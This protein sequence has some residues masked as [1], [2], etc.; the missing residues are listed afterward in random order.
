MVR[1]TPVH[2]H[3][4]TALAALAV[5]AC[6]TL[7][8]HWWTKPGGTVA[9]AGGVESSSSAEGPHRR[10]RT[11]LVLLYFG[12]STCHWCTSVE[13]LEAVRA[14]LAA[15]HGRAAQAGY[16]VTAVGV[17]LDDD[18]DEGLRY[19]ADV[20]KWDQIVS[21]GS[22]NNLVARHVLPVQGT[23][24]LAVFMRTSSRIEVPGGR[25]AETTRKNELIVR[26]VGLFEIQRW[27]ELGAPI[28]VGDLVPDQGQ[29]RQKEIPEEL[30]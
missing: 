20:A 25:I 30:F 28:P 4:M 8:A 5:F 15:V 9:T 23:P 2:R 16:E 11:E 17:A 24:E 18:I 14:A 6:A 22:W 21:G 29:P 3:A 13:G 27:L 7:V 26:K 10:A 19:L 12:R 1:Q